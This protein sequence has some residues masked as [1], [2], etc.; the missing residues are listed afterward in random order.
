VCIGPRPDLNSFPWSLFFGIII[1]ILSA[2]FAI[3]V[4][5]MFSDQW[6]AIRE[7][8]T[9]IEALKGKPKSKKTWKDFYNGLVDVFGDRISLMWLVPIQGTNTPKY[10]DELMQQIVEVRNYTPTYDYGSEE[11]EYVQHSHDDGSK[12]SASSGDGGARGGKSSRTK[13]LIKEATSR[14]GKK[15]EAVGPVGGWDPSAD[16]TTNMMNLANKTRSSTREVHQD[17]T[18]EDEIEEDSPVTTK[19]KGVSHGSALMNNIF[20]NGGGA[21]TATTD[22]SQSKKTK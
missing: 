19:G 16:T 9:Y 15:G 14:G 21:T 3:F 20:G 1:G 13:D 6:E 5:A 11:D 4:G 18:D 10:I 12:S 2:F 8:L 17:D 22:V 7:D